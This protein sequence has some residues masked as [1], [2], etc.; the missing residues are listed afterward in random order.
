MEDGLTRLRF[1]M[2]LIFRERIGSCHK[3]VFYLFKRDVDII[4]WTVVM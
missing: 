4:G 1:L 2:I 3:N